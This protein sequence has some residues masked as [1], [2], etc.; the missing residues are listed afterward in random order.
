MQ[1]GTQYI[2]TSLGYHY[3]LGED[4]KCEVGSVISQH[5]T[6]QGYSLLQGC[7]VPRHGADFSIVGAA[8]N[9]NPHNHSAE[10]VAG[11]AEEAEVVP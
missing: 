7:T 1:P 9:K 8:I 5:C 10:Q 11:E 6:K 4:F 3:L 2:N